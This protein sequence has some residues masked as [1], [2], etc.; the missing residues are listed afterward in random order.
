MTTILLGAASANAAAQ[1]L[2]RHTPPQILSPKGD[3][4][5]KLRARP[6]R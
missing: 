3:W 6:W 5:N 1:T 2:C 4:L